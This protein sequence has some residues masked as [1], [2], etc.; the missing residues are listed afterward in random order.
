VE[1]ELLVLVTPRLLNPL[2]PCQAPAVVPGQQTVSPTDGQFFTSGA[3]ESARRDGGPPL[4]KHHPHQLG[5]LIG[6]AA[7]PVPVSACPGGACPIGAHQTLLD[8]VCPPPA[9]GAAPTT[10]APPMPAPRPMPQ[11]APVVPLPPLPTNVP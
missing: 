5:D 2:D 8:A 6:P 7:L 1:S 4:G 10:L 3:L 9:F 11:P